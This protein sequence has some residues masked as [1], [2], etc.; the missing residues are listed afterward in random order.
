MGM[1]DLEDRIERNTGWRAP[2]QRVELRPSKREW[3][4]WRLSLGLLFWLV[5]F[6]G[7]IVAMVIA[8]LSGHHRD[9]RRAAVEEL[10]AA[11]TEPQEPT[12]TMTEVS[13]GVYHLDFGGYLCDTPQCLKRA[14][15]LVLERVPDHHIVSI[16]PIGAYGS[17]SAFAIVT[18]PVPY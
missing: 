16:A 4:W 5:I 8:A 10:A 18:V 12:I 2:R 6:T 11:T 13:A 1:G 9:E 7:F 3:W 17:P 15:W 14:S